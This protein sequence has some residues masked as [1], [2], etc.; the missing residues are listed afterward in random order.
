MVL[1]SKALILHESLKQCRIV[2]VTDRVDLETQL[3][4]TF[5]S[6]GELAGKK[7][8]EAAMATSGRRL[9]EQIGKGTERYPMPLLL[10]SLARHC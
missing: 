8:K 6:G 10:H 5:A 2:V 7:D 4:K 3:S 9:A 1:L